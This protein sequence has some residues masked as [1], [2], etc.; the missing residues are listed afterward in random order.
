MADFKKQIEE[1]IRAYQEK[2]GA[3]M[4]D[5]NKEEWAFNFW[6]LD[7]FFY[8]DEELIVDKITDYKDYGIDEYEWYKDTKEL[9]LIQNKFYGEDTK[10]PLDYI[11]NTFLVFLCSE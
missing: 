9:Y 5:I 3:T 7:K 4:H 8:E 2:Y 11:K 6:I 10:L 1:D